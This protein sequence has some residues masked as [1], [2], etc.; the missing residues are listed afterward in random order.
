MTD[1]ILVDT[2]ILVYAY[3]ST[4]L[5]KHEKSRRFLDGLTS[6]EV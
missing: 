2:N 1:K 5:E 4:G 3:V 6:K